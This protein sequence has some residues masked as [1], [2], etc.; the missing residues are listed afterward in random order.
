VS[1]ARLI[2]AGAIALAAAGV[3]SA[4]A[5]AQYYRGKTITV[6]INYPPGGANDI[7]GRI[8][9]RHLPKHIAGKPRIIVKNTAGGGG[10]IGVNYLGEI[11]KPD[12]LTMGYV[13]WNVI[14]AMLGDPGLR[15]R[16]SDLVLIAGVPNPVVFYARRDTAPG[17]KQPADIVKAKPFKALS[18]DTS[19]TNTI[20][21]ALAYD[22]IGAKYIAVAGYRGLKEVETAVLQGE[23]QA[24]NISLPGWAGSSA[25]ALVNSGIALPLWQLNGAGPDGSIAR[26]PAIPD[27]PTFEE[28]YQQVHGKKPSGI[29]YETLRLLIDSLT[30]MFRTAF[31]PPKTVPAAVK[32]MRAA[33]VTLFQDREFL[34]D[35]QRA[36]RTE[37][38]LVKGEDGEKIMGRLAGVKPEIKTFL[39]GYLKKLEK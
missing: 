36:V 10:N 35:Y 20:H 19:N 1:I 15:V 16:Y 22:V 28:V 14:A 32:E 30:N 11:A 39:A 26:F 24:G 34:S 29:E 31:M 21:Q 12:G 5:D 3:L 18:L 4:P 7:E 9:A 25:P 33:F 37:P 2:G 17:L 6:I 27:I 38:R 23:G 13:T 8:I